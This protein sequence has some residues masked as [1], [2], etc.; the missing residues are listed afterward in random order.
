MARALSPTVT[1]TESNGRV[2]AAPPRRSALSRVR[3]SLALAVVFAVLA[4]LFYLV[5]AGGQ[6]GVP[7]AV[8]AH[9][10]QAGEALDDAAVRFVDVSASEQFLATLVGPEDMAGL[11]GGVLSRPIA[12]G[13]AVG[14]A[15]VVAATAGGQARSMSIPVEPEHAAGGALQVGDLVDVIDGGDSAGPPSYAVTGVRVVA[16]SSRRSGTVG[17][18]ASKSWITV[19][20][21]DGPLPDGQA[22]LA[23]AAAIAHGKVEVVRSTGAAVLAPATGR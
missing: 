6:G 16:V 11:R 12:N 19:A 15:D 3:G 20:L 17:S 23:M 22:A 13:T 1:T 7:V 2:L 14:R 8:A 21:P 18:A 5:A 10:L 4:A 9:D